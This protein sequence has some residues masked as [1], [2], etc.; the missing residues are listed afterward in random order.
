MNPDITLP[1]TQKI[2]VYTANITQTGTNDPTIV[3][4]QNTLN[5]NITWTRFG[6]GQYQ[7]VITAGEFTPNTTTVDISNNRS[8]FK[9]IAGIVNTNTIHVFTYSS[10]TT[11]SDNALLNTRFEIKIYN[12]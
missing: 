11:Q 10:G 3:I 6:I 7:G 4:L 1:K 5:Y 12:I 9:L 2:R 8:T